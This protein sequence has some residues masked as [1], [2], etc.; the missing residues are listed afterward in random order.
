MFSPEYFTVAA[1]SRRSEGTLGL[2]LGHLI[3]D[4]TPNPA[5]VSGTTGFTQFL[6]E[7]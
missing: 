6:K 7:N 5:T 2:C 3:K 1:A 4:F